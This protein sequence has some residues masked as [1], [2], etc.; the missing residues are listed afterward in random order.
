MSH[1]SCNIVFTREMREMEFKD[2]LKELRMQ[3][4]YSQASLAKQLGLSASTISMYEVGLREPD[5]EKLELI[6]DFFNVDINYLLGKETVSTYL[7][8]PEAAE[9]AKELYEREELRVLFDA[10]RNASP[11]DIMTV[12]RMLKG[13][14]KDE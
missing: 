10:S 3:R 5:F 13:L 2:R 7:L 1:D 12:A 4:G 14:S 9:M 11:E 6:A 8:D